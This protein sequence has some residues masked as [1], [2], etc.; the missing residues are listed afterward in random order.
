MAENRKLFDTDA[1]EEWAGDTEPSVYF[2]TFGRWDKSSY[3]NSMYCQVSALLDD[4]EG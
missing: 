3:S 4:E 1:F 2:P